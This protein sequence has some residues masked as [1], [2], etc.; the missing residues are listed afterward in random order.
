MPSHT[1]Q[2]LVDIATQLGILGAF[3]GG[4]AATLLVALLLHEKRQRVV[5]AAIVFAAL[6][7]TAFIVAVIGATNLIS[8]LHPD[9]LANHA[10]P[11]LV[12]LSRL[13]MSAGFAIGVYA[14]FGCIGVSGWIRSPLT[15]WL[16]TAIGIVGLICVSIL[17]S[18]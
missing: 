2:Y 3:L 7:A 13:T 5:V 14:L 4:F 11:Q 12:Q 8:Q 9:A 18:H 15:G 16:T 6:S 1:P 17:L 10:A